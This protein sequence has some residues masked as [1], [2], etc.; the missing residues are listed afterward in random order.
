MVTVPYAALNQLAG[1][2]VPLVAWKIYSMLGRLRLQLGD[3]SAAEALEKASAIVQMIAANVEDEKLRASFLGAPAV[4]E[5]LVRQSART[6][7]WRTA[8]P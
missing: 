7:G 6:S 3:G 8:T 5:V 2:P 1:Y 4:R